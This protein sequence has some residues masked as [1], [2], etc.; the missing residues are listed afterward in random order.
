MEHKRDRYIPSLSLG[1]L[2]S[3]YDPIIRWTTRENT[4]KRS[5]VRQ[6]A[7]Q[8]GHRILD[9]GCGTATLTILI[10]EMHPETEVIGLDGDP[11][12][13][14]IARAKIDK[15]GLAITLTEG[16]AFALPY[17]NNSFDRVLSSLVFHHLTAENKKRTLGEVFRVLRPGGEFYLADFG[18]PGNLPMYLI[19]LIMRRLEE[20]SDNIR[21]LLPEMCREAGFEQVKE[22]YRFST[23][24]GSLSLYQARKPD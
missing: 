24:F 5:L 13:L 1:W 10:K 3:F 11:K 9:L 6:A 12:I 19:S 7:I 2:T 14:K 20:T 21:G 15:A 16:M 8:K 23:V 18:K 17:D 4:F 22:L